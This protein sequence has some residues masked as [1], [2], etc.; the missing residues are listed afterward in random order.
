LSTIESYRLLQDSNGSVSK[1]AA[2]NGETAR[3]ADS[4]VHYSANAGPALRAACM[5][6]ASDA[7]K[8]QNVDVSAET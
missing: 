6:G 3:T 5:I 4:C 7:A 8:M 2:S 1:A